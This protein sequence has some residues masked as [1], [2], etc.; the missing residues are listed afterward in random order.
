MNLI[1]RDDEDRILYGHQL[2][3][4]IIATGKNNEV[5]V[6]NG[7]EAEI[8]IA[9]VW[10]KFPENR[11]VEALHRCGEVDE[12]LLEAVSD[13]IEL[14]IEDMEAMKEF[15]NRQEGDEWKT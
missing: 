11:A 10:T 9:Y 15:Q 5:L 8:F 4:H 14:T 3:R 6:C 7:I 12:E 2:L 1:I 13:S